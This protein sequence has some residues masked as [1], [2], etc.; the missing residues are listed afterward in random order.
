MKIKLPFIFVVGICFL[1]GMLGYLTGVSAS[2]LAGTMVSSVFG[3]A[4]GAI[5]G[6][7]RQSVGYQRQTR[8]LKQMFLASFPRGV[9]H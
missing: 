1:G 2:P 6:L 7:L 3:E 8:G 4:V 5:A 9:L